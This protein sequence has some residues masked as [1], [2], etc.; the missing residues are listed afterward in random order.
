MNLA[1]EAYELLTTDS[2]TLEGCN[3]F[4]G[5]LDEESGNLKDLYRQ[6]S[7]NKLS[8]A[9]KRKAANLQNKVDKEMARARGVVQRLITAH[10]DTSSTL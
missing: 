10:E 5:E 3:E 1:A 2:W 8:I 9:M 6:F 4:M 7:T